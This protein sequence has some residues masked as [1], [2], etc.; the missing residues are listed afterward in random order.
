MSADYPQLLDP[1]RAAAEEMSISGQ[2]QLSQLPGL[3][4]KLDPDAITD[5]HH[6][7]FNANFCRDNHGRPLVE[8][9]MS[10]HVP[11][12]C[13]RSLMHFDEMLSAISSV[14]IVRD[15]AEAERV[16]EAY[17]P[18]LLNDKLLAIRELVAE[19][20]VLA[21]PLVPIHADAEV[22][23]ADVLDQEDAEVAEQA[24]EP[25][26]KPFAGLAELMNKE[27]STD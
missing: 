17:E 2:I 6:V 13:Q 27:E 16:D 23:R 19:E 7:S 1:W 5:T 10:A 15:E 20:L 14:V 21:I 11:L 22:I 9:S 4:G 12:V 26:R 8:L 24:S 3:D 18:V 25:R